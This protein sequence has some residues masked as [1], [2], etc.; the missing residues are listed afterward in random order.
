WS[1]SRC[2]VKSTRRKAFQRASNAAIEE[3]TPTFNNRVKRS[4]RIG[5]I[6]SIARL[7]PW[8]YAS[9]LPLYCK[10]VAAENGDSRRGCTAPCYTGAFLWLQ[11]RPPRRASKTRGNLH[12]WWRTPICR[13]ALA[14]SPFMGSLAAGRRRKR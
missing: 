9:Q 11:N 6:V 13:R 10:E 1:E 4:S 3:A 5:G 8:A 2:S 14:A 7:Q 12:D